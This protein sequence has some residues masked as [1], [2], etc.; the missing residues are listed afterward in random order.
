MGSDDLVPYVYAERKFGL[1]VTEDIQIGA[2]V[3]AALVGT[4][5]SVNSL[6]FNLVTKAHQSNMPQETVNH[7]RE[8]RQ[9]ANK[10]YE[11]TKNHNESMFQ[12]T[13]Q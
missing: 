2:L 7:N 3:V 8:T 11:I 4:C 6:Y 1:S 9:L 12:A 5:N 10:T 13:V